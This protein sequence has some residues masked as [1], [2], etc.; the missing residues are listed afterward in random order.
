MILDVKFVES[1][2]SFAPQFGE[3]YNV[4]DGDY[5]RGY[6]AGYTDGETE[7]CEN[8]IGGEW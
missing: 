5:E 7:I 8:L 3:V 6:A 1:D 4:S 2:Q